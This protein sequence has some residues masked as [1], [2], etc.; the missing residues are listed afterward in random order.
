MVKLQNKYP[1]NTPLAVGPAL[2][3]GLGEGVK[4]PGEPLSSHTGSLL[5]K[6]KM[7]NNGVEPALR[8]A[9]DGESKVPASLQAQIDIP[10][11]PN[12]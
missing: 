1:G 10:D 6:Q 9:L 5:Q 12:L 4:N 11:E 2:V 7:Q 8:A 3:A